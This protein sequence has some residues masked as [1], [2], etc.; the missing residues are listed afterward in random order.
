MKLI[1][2]SLQRKVALILITIITTVGCGVSYVGRNDMK[3]LKMPFEKAAYPDTEF[4]F[5]SIQSAK[6]TGVKEFIM[7]AARNAAS[8]DLAGKISSMIDADIKTQGTVELG[9]GN[10]SGMTTSRKEQ[11]I[12]ASTN[13]MRVVDEKW[14][15]AGKDISGKTI[16]EYW[17]VYRIATADVRSLY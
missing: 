6:A 11:I 8:A 15:D 7:D 4:Y 5:H 10:S 14:F 1:I 3:E 17:A 16:Y 12:K 13:K 9:G 2:E